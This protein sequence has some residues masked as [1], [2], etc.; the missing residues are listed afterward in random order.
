MLCATA[1]HVSLL[2]LAALCAAETTRHVYHQPLDH[3]APGGGGGTVPQTYFVNSDHF[4]GGPVILYS[5]GERGAQATDIE[6]SL[7]YDM[8][9]QTQ[10][11]VVLLEQRFYG[12]SQPNGPDQLQFLSVEQMMGDIYR[13][14]TLANVTGDGRTRRPWVLV[15]GSFAGSLAAWT[16]HAYPALGAMVV[17][18]SAPMRL[19]DGYWGFDEAAAQRIPCAPALSQA[20]RRI[21]REL[22]SG[23]DMRVRTIKRLF[24]LSPAQSAE[25]LAGVLT[26]RLAELAPSP[27][28][29]AADEEIGDFC[30]ELSSGPPAVALARIT[31]GLV[32]GPR[33][34]A[35]CPGGDERA[36]L[37]LQCTQ[38][39]LW[40]TAP[41]VADR[42]RFAH[43]LRSRRL[44]VAYFDGVCRRCFPGFR[45][46]RQEFR[47][48]ADRAR[49]AYEGDT[50]SAVFSV[51]ELDPWRPL[52]VGGAWVIAGAA[53]AQDLQLNDEEAP[54]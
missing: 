25:E 51:G 20:V 27:V 24:G 36:W 41:P 4:N 2:L 43:R 47:G 26:V 11:V 48:F 10:A 12:A 39:G 32:G 7:V 5:V 45:P 8:A 30:H 18:S 37:W 14:A 46:R 54:P 42:V 15:G 1:V 19:V 52:A 16:G 17:A 35:E 21:D 44:T 31:R 22:D 49:R 50:R 9:R 23:D 29:P 6:D 53:H 28:G 38:I 40:Q 33:A 3:F 34:T 13:F